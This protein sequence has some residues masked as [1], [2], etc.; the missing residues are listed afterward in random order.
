MNK[1]INKL[2]SLTLLGIC[3]ISLSAC[4]NDPKSVKFTLQDPVSVDIH[5]EHQAA[6]LEDPNY[7]NIGKYSAFAEK[8]GYSVPAPIL[9]QW[10]VTSAK[11]YV[12]KVSENSD[13]SNAMSYETA[14]KG[15]VFNFYNAKLNT[16]YYWT[17]TAN[18]KSNSFTSEVASFT[19]KD[20]ILRNIFVD[21]VDN[22]RDLG[23]YKTSSNK[24]VKQGLVYRSGQ[25][26]KDK[27]NDNEP[28]ATAD[29]Q[30]V[31]NEQLK[32]K[33]DIDLR[34]SVPGDDGKIEN[35][36]LNESPISKEVV[37][38]S[39]PMYYDGQNMLEHSDPNKLER[40]LQSV[41]EFFDILSD[42]SSYPV[43]FHCVQGKDR[44][45]LL[46]YL[47]GALLGE[48]ETDLYRDYL[49]TN[50][51]TSVGSPCKSDDISKRY[52]LTI[53]KI[54]GSSLA[55]KTYNY[56]HNTLSIPVNTL[57]AVIDN[58]CE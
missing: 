9:L 29:G 19:T 3:A 4:E 17:V 55:E 12:I 57:D 28:L 39:L 13:M 10:K 1:N 42:K 33:T 46:S 50:F 52:G 27:V 40:N 56:L 51:S 23:G 36:G 15:K 41:C 16:K 47:L 5:T 37:Y 35:S 8:E 45:G 2:L 20:T 30:K 38:R 54:E 6:F 48:S 25:L 53:N 34:K 7:N 11:S 26:N 49:F 21:G 24:V 18:Y 32:I 22:V 14:S 31:L 44:T 58:L 43:V